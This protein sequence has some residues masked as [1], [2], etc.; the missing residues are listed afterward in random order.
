MVSSSVSVAEAY[1]NEIKLLYVGVTRSKYGLYMSYSGAISILFP[2]EADSYDFH[3]G[4][5]AM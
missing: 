4:E 2:Q 1:A 3:D 5:S